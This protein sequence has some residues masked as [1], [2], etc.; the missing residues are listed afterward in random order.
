MNVPPPLPPRLAPRPPDSRK[1]FAAQ[2]A[3]ASVFAPL[4]AVVVS[5]MVNVGEGIGSSS[6]AKVITAAL[7]ILLIVLG[8][9]L[10]VI[11]LFGIRRHGRKGI[12]ANAIAGVCINGLLIAFMLLSIPIYMKA[13]ARAKQMRSEQSADQR[14][15]PP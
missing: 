11:A 5:V 12:M 10:G 2:A 6:S 3:Q 7:S 15:T 14:H 13:A 8:L 9:A 1:P 4:A